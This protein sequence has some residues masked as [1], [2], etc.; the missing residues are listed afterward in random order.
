MSLFLTIDNLNPETLSRL[1][2]E[3][4]RRGVDVKEI[5]QDR[6][7]PV[8]ESNATET[9]HDLVSEAVPE[10]I[11]TRLPLGR[12]TCLGTLLGPRIKCR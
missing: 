1:N 2:C 5:I 12:A 10:K 8:A 11:P 7:G 6:L 3:A 4:E 9:H